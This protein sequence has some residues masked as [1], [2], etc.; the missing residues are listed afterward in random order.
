MGSMDLERTSRTQPASAW[1]I[2]ASV[3]PHP[4]QRMDQG[5]ADLRL[6]RD[7]LVVRPEGSRLAVGVEIR[8]GEDQLHP[9]LLGPFDREFLGALRPGRRQSHVRPFLFRPV[10]SVE[11]PTG[12]LRAVGRRRAPEG[13]HRTARIRLPGLPLLDRPD[14]LF[15]LKL[16][17]RQMGAAPRSPPGRPDLPGRDRP[18]LR[19]RVPDQFAGLRRRIACSG[20][21]R[22]FLEFDVSRFR[23]VEVPVER[24]HRIARPV[25][26]AFDPPGRRMEGADQGLSQ[27]GLEILQ[28]GVRDDVDQLG[29]ER[30][31]ELNQGV[32]GRKRTSLVQGSGQVGQGGG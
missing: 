18:G 11:D 16:G 23:S 1:P 13:D 15:R 22:G 19:R 20:L 10:Q 30:A 14:R 7:E 17:R 3:L 25:R 6:E 5:Q 27:D 31:P 29:H 4:R 26:I 2:W 9:L 24:S 8:A 28:R 21:R 12:I 32:F